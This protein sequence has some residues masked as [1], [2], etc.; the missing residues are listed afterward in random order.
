MPPLSSERSEPPSP[1][2]RNF[3]QPSHFSTTPPPPCAK[4][5]CAGCKLFV[6]REVLQPWW[7]MTGNP[8]SGLQCVAYGSALPQQQQK[9]KQPPSF[10]RTFSWT[11]ILENELRQRGFWWRGAPQ[12]PVLCKS[13][14]DYRWEKVICFVFFCA[15]LF[16]LWQV[17]GCQVC[18]SKNGHFYARVRG[19]SCAAAVQLLT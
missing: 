15:L 5:S 3:L 2:L 18:L 6:L 1:C 10:T 8:E 16:A 7:Q 19:V 17:R 9:K 11:L 14:T 13:P 12:P 4:K